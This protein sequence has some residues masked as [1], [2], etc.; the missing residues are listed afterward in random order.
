ML[1]IF[2]L[3]PLAAQAVEFAMKIIGTIRQV[4]GSTGDEDDKHLADLEAR[5]DATKKEVE[6]YR[7][8]EV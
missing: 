6:D 5:L 2:A 1:P 3:L 8:R 4:R 7:P